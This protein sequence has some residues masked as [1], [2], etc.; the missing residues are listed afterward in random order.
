MFPLM[1]Q[2]LLQVVQNPPAGHHAARRDNHRR[3]ADRVKCLGFL[4]G[5]DEVNFL[6]ASKTQLGPVSCDSLRSCCPSTCSRCSSHRRPSDYRGRSA[7]GDGPLLHQRAHQVDQLLR[8]ANGK[9]RDDH[10]A[11]AAFERPVDDFGDLLQHRLG[12]MVAVAVGAFADQVIALRRRLGIVVQRRRVAADIARKEQPR[13][14]GRRGELRLRS[15]PI[16]ASAPHRDARKK[17]RPPQLDPRTAVV[18]L[19]QFDRAADIVRVKERSA[20]LCLEKPLRLRSRRLLLGTSPR[21][22]A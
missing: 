13:R 1:R 20:G 14:P 21:Q 11:T 22:R 18:R 3:S 4:A 16:R 5:A 6:A 17:R 9:C 7:L 12:R 8:A 2:T 15:S 19:Q 10:H